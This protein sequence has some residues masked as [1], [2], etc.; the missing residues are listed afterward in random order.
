MYLRTYKVVSHPE[1]LGIGYDYVQGM[2]GYV[3]CV[4]TRGSAM[5]TYE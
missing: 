3:S 5:R 4:M 2:V 1:Y